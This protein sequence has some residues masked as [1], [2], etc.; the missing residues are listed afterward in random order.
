[1]CQNREVTWLTDNGLLT[2][3]VLPWEYRGLTEGGRGVSH[4]DVAI[5]G[6]DLVVLSCGVS[7]DDAD[8]DVVLSKPSCWGY[9]L[10]DLI[11]AQAS[12]TELQILLA[13]L[14]DAVVPSEG[15]LFRTSPAVKFY[16]L[17][18]ELFQLVDGVLYKKREDTTGMDLVIPV[19]LRNSALESCHD[20][21]TAG[22]QGI[23]RTRARVKEMFFWYGVGQ[24]V[25]RYVT[26]C[27]V[28]SRNKK[29][30]RYGRC[31]M[32]E[33]QAGA[34]LERVHIDFLGPLPKT[35][36]GNEHI[37]MIVDQFTKWVECIPLPSQTAEAT[38]KAAVNQFFT[39][40]GFPF[41]I[42]SDQGRN[43]ESKLFAAVCDALHIHKTRT[44]PYRPSA[45]GQV[46][47]YNRTLMDAVRCYIGKSQ[48]R[49]DEHLSQ[50]AMALRASVN[51]DSGFTANKLMLGREVNTPAYLMFPQVMDW[52]DD[53]E[54]YVAE[55]IGKIQVAH[56]VARS[57]LK[58]STKRMKR[59]Y[60]LRILERP[61]KEGDVVYLLDTASIKGKCKKLKSPWKGPG[62][63][64]EKLS[65]C[66]YRV[67]LQRA[68][69]V[70]NHD[71]MKPCHDRKLPAWV[72]KWQANPSV[73]D[74]PAKDDGIVYCSCK[75]AWSGRFMIQCD[76]C[77]VWY[78][79][80]CVNVTATD[81]LNIGRYKCVGCRNQMRNRLQTQST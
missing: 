56:D 2:N 46:E 59:S 38:A 42:L 60:D 64:V 21:P 55:L 1:L 32:T 57:T 72:Q 58:T 27:D 36:N 15:D 26:T 74:E 13:W 80:S 23:T 17:N 62:V 77:D 37:L 22:H 67:K 61:Y 9:T 70:T 41:Q 3:L 51:R 75:K 24:D 50:I 19:Q 4:L 34:P 29:L 35:A 14:K 71:R 48:N 20:L 73:S 45:N 81:A 31:P 68:L 30:N 18:K 53:P 16:W 78:H 8:E 25:T 39:K 66:V 6:G 69:F 7:K 44:T 52:A 5:E 65:A 43:F 49:W 40:F 11:Q 28:C 47:R 54:A 10:E 76:F 79:G 33:F 12:D 63:I